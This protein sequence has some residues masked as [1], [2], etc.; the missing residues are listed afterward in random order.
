MAVIT[1]LQDWVLW[2]ENFSLD[3]CMHINTY[4]TNSGTSMNLNK[5]Y[6]RV[7]VPTAYTPLHLQQPSF[8]FNTVYIKIGCINFILLG[9]NV[10]HRFQGPHGLRRGSVAARLLG[11]Q[12]RIPPGAWLSHSCRCCVMSNI[13]L[14]MGLITRPE[15][16]YRV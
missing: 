1:T 4:N 10:S 5:E 6:C 8:I 14:C 12:V 2:I 15:E 7:T 9:I 13:G 16:S 3:V 11:L